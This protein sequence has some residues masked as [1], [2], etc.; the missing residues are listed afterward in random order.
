MATKQL[1][2][3]YPWQRA[4]YL[5][6]LSALLLVPCF[7]TS[8][9]AQLTPPPGYSAKLLSIDAVGSKAYSVA[10]VTQVSGL[11]LGATVNL[12]AIQAA[13]DRLAHS[14]LFSAVHY[15]YATDVGGLRVTFELHD[16]PSFPISLDNFPWFTD[17]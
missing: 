11:S 13:A 4:H 12:D 7:G 6:L 9:S 10:Q 5:P 15:R 16:A 3:G 17:N 1:L 2:L 8:A 14:G